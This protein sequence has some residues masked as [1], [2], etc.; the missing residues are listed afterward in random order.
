VDDPLLTVRGV[1][2]ERP[3]TRVILD[4]RLRT[5]PA[6]RVLSTLA[7]GEVIIVATAAA[8][9]DRVQA[10]GALAAAGARIESSPDG[11]IA[12]ALTRLAALG[13]TSIILEGGPT[14][15]Q[16]AWEAGVVDRIHVYRSRVTLGTS[17]VRAFDGLNRALAAPHDRRTVQLGN[18]TFE[19]AYV[20][21]TD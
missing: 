20:H 12:S 7:S 3:F 9:D 14:V 4:R 6:A 15:Q 13:I 2:R 21:G 17:G 5:P 18:D 19:E 10:V 11:T 1:Y 8:L 16:A